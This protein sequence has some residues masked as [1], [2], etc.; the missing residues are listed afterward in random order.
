MAT[1]GQRVLEQIR[2]YKT[3][4]QLARANSL[5]S[6]EGRLRLEDEVKRSMDA[7]RIVAAKELAEEWAD[8]RKTFTRIDRQLA[9]A[10]RSARDSWDYPRLRHETCAALEAVGRAADPA[11]LET[12][13]GEL[14]ALGDRSRLR[15]WQEAAPSAILMRWPGDRIAKRLAKRIACELVETLNTPELDATRRSQTALAR[16]AVEAYVATEVARAEFYPGAAAGT[17]EFSYLLSEVEL[18]RLGDMELLG[19]GRTLTVA[20]VDPIKMSLN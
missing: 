1:A 13:Y 3:Q 17:D 2:R 19:L 15:A 11:V 18:A 8:I 4:I 20:A 12:S 7:Y 5:L 6:S 9:S 10:E 14:L 16:R